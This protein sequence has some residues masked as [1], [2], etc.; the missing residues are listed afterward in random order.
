MTHETTVE[1]A[2]RGD[3]FTA[4]AACTCGWSHRELLDDSGEFAATTERAEL[5][6]HTHRANWP[7]H[8]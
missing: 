4:T 3:D 8:H 2:G 5:A 1:T 6:A 7:A